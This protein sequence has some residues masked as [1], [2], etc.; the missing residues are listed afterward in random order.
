MTLTPKA[1]LLNAELLRSVAL[2]WMLVAV[3]TVIDRLGLVAETGAA[4]TLLFGKRA[5]NDNNTVVIRTGRILK[6]VKQNELRGF[7]NAF[8]LLFFDIY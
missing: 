8:D 2:K 1:W 4:E 5:K 3:S 6:I 7:C